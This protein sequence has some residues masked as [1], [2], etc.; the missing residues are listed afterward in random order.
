[1]SRRILFVEDVTY[2]GKSED[3]LSVDQWVD[4]DWKH[5]V[6]FDEGGQMKGAGP[7]YNVGLHTSVTNSIIDMVRSAMRRTKHGFR[8]R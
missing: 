5:K 8:M 7:S 1:M 6:F 4:I 2:N 3:M